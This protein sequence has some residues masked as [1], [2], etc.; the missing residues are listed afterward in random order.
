MSNFLQEG[1]QSSEQPVSQFIRLAVQKMVQ[2]AVEQEVSDFLGRE[3]YERQTEPVGYRNGYKRGRIRSAE[4]EIPVQVPQVR[5]TEAAYHS[6]LLAFLR[7]N[8][9]VLE[10]LV[11][12]MYS[13]GLSTRDVEDAFRDPYTGEMLLSRSAVSE[14]TVVCGKTTS[15]SASAI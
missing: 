6:K 3:R 10:Y 12:Q 11:T 2:E 15:S 7:G 8:S 14:I 13:R 9:D 1:I 4:G 5:G